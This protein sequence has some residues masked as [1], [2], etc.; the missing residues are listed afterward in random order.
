MS[1]TKRVVLTVAICTGLLIVWQFLFGPT[2]EQRQR[3]LDQQAKQQQ[4]QQQQ[5]QA[6]TEKARA[7]EAKAGGGGAP[8]SQSTSKPTIKQGGD[9]SL[10][11]LIADPEGVKTTLPFKEA[12]ASFSNR[13]ATLRHWVLK[14]PRYKEIKEGKLQQ[15]DL[16][17][18]PAKKGPWQL[19]T[20]FPDS[21]FRLPADAAFKLVKRDERQ[22]RYEWQSQKVRVSKHYLLDRTRPVIWMTLQVRNLTD[23]A[24]KQRLRVSVFSHQDEGQKPGL[25]NPYP[26]M[27]TG[28]CFVN[29]ELHRRSLGA[30]TGEQ[31][32][33][34]AGSCGMGDGPVAQVGDVSWVAADDR[35]FL[36][37]VVPLGSEEQERRCEV[38][39]R[40]G[41]RLV[42]TSLLFSEGNIAAGAVISH[43]FAVYVG[44]KDINQLDAVKTKGGIPAQLD[45]SVEFG[46]F[47]VL[48]R[49]MI[50][51]L[52]FFHEIFGNWGLAII[53]LTL[54][55]KLLTLY[56][57]QK[58]M[59]SMKN[60]QLVKPKMDEL[61][62]K[63]GHDKQRLNQEMMQL[64][65]VHKINPFG[66]CLPMLL[67]MPIWFALY[68]TLGNA[69]ELYRSPFFGWITDLTAP[70]P[71][72][73]LPILMGLAMYGQQA[74]T[75]QPLEGTQAKMM[76]Y[77][78]PGMFTV[79]MLWLPAGLTLYIFVNTVL[80]MLHQF[81]M[82]RTDPSRKGGGLKTD[83]QRAA[84]GKA[85]VAEIRATAATGGGD[86]GQADVEGS[87]GQSP[88]GPKR[89]KKRRK[90]KK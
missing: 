29:G 25:A 26:R 57:T 30:I 3:M 32:G 68:R 38:N 56:P 84:E 87:E 5:Q 22:V 7:P 62:K 2:P 44:A 78:M 41:G 66:G 63:Y 60:L 33:C 21:D 31:S 11:P 46:W 42:E 89:K 34:A 80:T 43:R 81:H 58:S 9:P 12:T 10:G 14:H 19:L 37:A 17:Q 1:S 64:Y 35:Y 90:S 27:A 53:L 52:K 65:R 36:T 70:D 13:G 82:N 49:P 73:V 61:R 85:K 88:R 75:P 79:M 18:A 39:K 45:Q 54:V 77:F 67:Q 83:A 24:L 6:G 76:K 72:Y 40:E 69:V 48:C 16:V 59:R 28:L 74:I 47:A 55:I 71:Y 15:V 20:T 86:Q 4:Q 8:G 23:R 51:L 50:A